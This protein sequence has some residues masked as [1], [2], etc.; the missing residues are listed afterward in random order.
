M[1]RR[2]PKAPLTAK[3]VSS[4]KRPG[5]YSDSGSKG[6]YLLIGPSGAKSWILRYMLNKQRR[7]M[8]LGPVG[9]V[10]LAD[11]RDKAHE[12]RKALLAK[13][14]PLK[15]RHDAEAKKKLE[16]ANAKT[17]K[18][19]VLDYIEDHKSEWSS[20]K[21]GEQWRR[22]FEVH[23]FDLIGQV[24]ISSIDTEQ[25]LKVL[26]PIWTKI[27][28]TAGRVRGRME[29]VLDAATAAKHRPEVP[30][31]ARWKGHLKHMLAKHNRSQSVQHHPALPFKD[32]P[33]F[34]TAL[35]KMEGV[36]PKALEF[37]ILT[38][39]RTTE[40]IGARWSEFDIPAKTWIIPK[41]RMKTRKEH[42]VPLGE[43]AIRILNA[44]MPP[45]SGP[46]CE[47][48]FRTVGE[49]EPLSNN[50]CLTLLE[51]MSMGHITVHGF[52]SS[53]RDWAS[54]T[55]QPFSHAAME[56]ALAHKVANAVEGAYRRGDMF[57]ERRRLMKAWASFCNSHKG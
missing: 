18:Q 39:T 23:C 2:I 46:K 28:E 11:A 26:K 56:Q 57:D 22:T 3:A 31:P 54:E 35:R 17:F 48:V 6:L 24:P 15:A 9:D 41:E 51:R 34:M 42:R 33:K 5:R 50:A 36:S 43:D 52:R 16:A 19:C 53:F 12:A 30:N 37:L 20:D 10:S 55:A 25:V 4:L 14:D 40:T 13:I 32:V 38:A 47:F 27:P 29:A 21:H 1:A 7:E 49:D 8:G 45:A 44:V